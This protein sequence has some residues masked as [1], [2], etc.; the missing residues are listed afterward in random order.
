MGEISD[1]VPTPVLNVGYCDDPHYV[2]LTDI[3]AALEG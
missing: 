1:L 3:E 2:S